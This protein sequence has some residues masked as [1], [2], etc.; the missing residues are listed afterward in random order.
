VW[1]WCAFSAL[2]FGIFKKKNG[3][4]LRAHFL[5]HA[6]VAKTASVGLWKGP[7]SGNPKVAGSILNTGRK[8]LRCTWARHLTPNHTPSAT[9]WLLQG[10]CLWF[11]VCIHYSLLLT[12][13][14][15]LNADSEYRS[16]CLAF[17]C[18]FKKKMINCFIWC[19]VSLFLGLL[20]STSQ[21]C[22]AT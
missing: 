15:G 12:N 20:H 2:C 7:Q 11:A 16:P 9:K 18:H 21:L 4:V 14:D 1:V 8:W 6:Q 10:G 17:T 13:L 5:T 22:I 19:F 3:T